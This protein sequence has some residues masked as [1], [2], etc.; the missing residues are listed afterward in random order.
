MGYDSIFDPRQLNLVYGA[1]PFLVYTYHTQFFIHRL[2]SPRLTQALCLTLLFFRLLFFRPPPRST[3]REYRSLTRFHIQLEEKECIAWIFSFWTMALD[4]N[5]GTFAVY[6]CFL[7]ASLN[8]VIKTVMKMLCFWKY[9]KT[10][11]VWLL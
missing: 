2:N 5:Y 8:N 10:I 1:F 3:G 9:C 11:M 6:L 7:Y 4:S